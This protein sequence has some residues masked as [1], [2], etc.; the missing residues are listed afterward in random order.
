M[1]KKKDLV[2]YFPLLSFFKPDK[3]TLGRKDDYGEG[4]LSLCNEEH[5]V[6]KTL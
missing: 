1:F 4:P 5:L 3:E 6:G 2:V